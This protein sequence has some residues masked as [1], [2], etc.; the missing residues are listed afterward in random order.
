[1]RGGPAELH[2]LGAV[3]WRRATASVL[4]EWV[5]SG[6]WS[7]AD[8]VRVAQMVGA[9]NANVSTGSG[10]VGTTRRRGTHGDVR[11]RLSD[12]RSTP[13]GKAT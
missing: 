3:L 8:A 10:V 11:R 2:H 1:M 12:R 9:D 4:G 7:S 13:L 5:Q 6:E